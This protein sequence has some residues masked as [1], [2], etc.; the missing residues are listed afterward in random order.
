MAE[1]LASSTSTARASWKYHTRPEECK[2]DVKKEYPP[3]NGKNHFQCGRPPPTPLHNMSMVQ[4]WMSEVRSPHRTDRKRAGREGRDWKILSALETL[5]VE[6]CLSPHI[7]QLDWLMMMIKCGD[8][9]GV[10]KYWQGDEGLVFRMWKMVTSREHTLLMDWMKEK[11][12][13]EGQLWENLYLH[14]ARKGQVKCLDWLVSNRIHLSQCDPQRIAIQ[15]LWSSSTETLHWLEQNY[16]SIRR[17]F[18]PVVLQLPDVYLSTLSTKRV[19]MKFLKWVIDR[20]GLHDDMMSRCLEHG[21]VEAVIY[22]QERGLHLPEDFR[23][24]PI[25]LGLLRHLHHHHPSSLNL[26]CTSHA[27]Q[28]I[29]ESNTNVLRWLMKK[30]AAFPQ[31]MV[32]KQNGTHDAACMILQI[33]MRWNIAESEALDWVKEGGGS[34]EKVW[35]RGR[36]MGL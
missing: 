17:P 7:E 27:R 9:E 4:W 18:D 13:L 22:L 20:V 31:R 19:N 3:W 16:Q 29:A 30:G 2:K 11:G 6:S 24:C 14:C 33:A 28:A 1:R 23:T 10:E 5:D 36:R 21:N 32:F 34:Y 8:L 26:N 15:C 12:I 25:H 35:Q